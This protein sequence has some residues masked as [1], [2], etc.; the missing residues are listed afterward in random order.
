MYRAL[1]VAVAFAL[2]PLTGAALERTLETGREAGAARTLDAV[3]SDPV[4]LRAFLEA[5]PKGADLHNH[6]DGTVYA[7]ALIGMGRADGLCV[8]AAFVSSNPPCDASKGQQPIENAVQQ[9]AWDKIVDAWSTRNVAKYPISG[10]DQFF[11]TFGK[12]SAVAS[13]HQGDIVAAA[14]RQADQD[15]VAYVELMASFGSDAVQK[16]ANSV[17]YGGDL[18]KLGADVT[19]AGLSDA[20]NAAAAEVQATDS[21]ARKAL[22]CDADAHALGCAV[23]Y[24]YIMSIGRTLPV[25]YVFTQTAVG[26][27]LA[28]RTPRVV[29]INYVAPE[30]NPIAIRDYDLHMHIIRMLSE[31]NPTVDISL[32][33]G[34]LT[35]GLVP[36]S[37]LDGHIRGAVEIAHAKRIG[38]G[39]DIVYERDHDRTLAEMRRQHI[40]VEIN[41]TS[42]DVILG[43]SGKRHPIML[44][45]RSGVP[46]ALSTDDEGVSRI[47]LTHEFQRAVETYGFSYGQLKAFVR[48]SLEYSFLPGASLWNGGRYGTMTAPCAGTD[49]LDAPRSLC[50][51]YLARNPKARQQWRVESQL[52]AFEASR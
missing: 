20:V 38:H 13:R 14:L 40:L 45:L 33:A 39:V 24:R 25:E 18:V 34:E 19:A 22:G 3:R 51:A 46:I 47:D 6:A 37:A 48:N 10:H 35:L 12:F 44:Y 52:A 17:H 29:A 49:P 4:R 7:E 1:I 27:A 28:K 11:S 9:G 32:H 31:A 30:D 42:N 15:H 21:A 16:I 8:N 2:T 50:D 36:R 41:L 23:E 43:V 5:M 26:F